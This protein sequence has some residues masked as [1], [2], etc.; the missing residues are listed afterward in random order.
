[1][2]IDLLKKEFKDIL[3]HEK[4]AKYFYEHYMDQVEDQQI[5]DELISIRNDE[6]AHIKI[7]ERLIECVSK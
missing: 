6:N 5:K 7:A 2:N 1:M 3:E 4:R